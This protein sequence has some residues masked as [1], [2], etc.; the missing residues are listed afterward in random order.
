MKQEKRK[1]RSYKATDKHY[2]RAQKKAS[3]TDKPLAER[4][5]EFVIE[6]GKPQKKIKGSVPLPADFLNI[7]SIGLLDSEG[8]VRKLL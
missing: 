7:K 2:I 6:Y 3:K 8:N 1:V 4:I 5:E